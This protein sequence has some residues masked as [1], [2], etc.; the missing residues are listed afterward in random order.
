MTNPETASSYVTDPSERA[1][2]PKRTLVFGGGYVG[3]RVAGLATTGGDEVFV[4]TRSDRKATEFARHGWH[5]I[6][7]DWKS[8][9]GLRSLPETLL[10]DMDR[11]LIAV[12]YDRQSSIS[13]HESQVIGLQR[14]LKRITR[15]TSVVYISTTGVY[16]QTDGR[17]VDENSPAHPRREG[18]R[19]H[20]AA[21]Q[22][23]RRLGNDAPWA[24]LR[25]A[26]IYGPGRVPLARSVKNGDPIASPAEG[27]LNLIH[28]D[29]A[30]E[31]TM[32]A[33][34][35]LEN[36]TA[37]HPRSTN[38][39][40]MADRMSVANRLFVVAD[41]APVIRREFYR[42]IARL[43]RVSDP[44]FTDAASN[45]NQSMRSASNKRI[46]NRGMKRHLRP[47]LSFPTYREGLSAI[48]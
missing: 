6:L 45:R 1:G 40:A 2:R 22:C 5:P 20:L 36:L 34:Q 9:T 25:L 11:I 24:I 44:V 13:R 41:D 3:R 27:F 17:W 8:E 29:D 28:V 23:I 46:W 21:E 48:L 4:T 31:V 35:R 18:G 19:I 33:W 37:C 26:G 10:R 39:S 14:L 38:G 7:A 12:S 42:E 30:A 16:H 15:H 32:A 47:Q 43:L